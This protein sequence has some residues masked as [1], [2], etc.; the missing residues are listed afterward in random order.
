MDTHW[1]LSRLLS[2]PHRLGFAAAALLLGTS[3]VWWAVVLATRAAGIA[4]P[5]AVPPPAA[6]G[7]VMALGFMPLFITGFLFTAGPRW[8]GLPEVDAASLRM[9]VQTIVAGWALAL[10]GFHAA[11]LLAAI[12]VAAVA[13]GWSALVLRFA[14]LVRISRSP[15]K[16]HAS[17]VAVAGA[18]GAVALWLAAA[19]LA[20]D[21]A[22]GVRAA[23]QLALWGFLAP[24]FAIVSHRM[25]PFFTASALPLH[26]AW[27]P[28]ALLWAMLAALVAELPFAIAELW[29]WPLP[30]AVRWLQVGVELPAAALLLWLALRWGLL[31]GLKIRLLAMLHVG[32]LWLGITFALGAVSHALVA[33]LG[34]AHSFDLAPQHALTMGYLGSTLLAM[35]TRVASGHSGR[36]LVADNIV[37][38]LFWTLQAAVLLRLAAAL[39]P[40]AATPLLLAAVSGWVVAMAGWALRYGRWLGRPRADGRPG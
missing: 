28:D 11:T 22:T 24:V 10:P 3:A 37:W 1:R 34:P 2:A 9:P 12:G 32:F 29:R 35:A 30:P 20:A 13:L 26:D 8:L 6:H 39:W 19:A 17:L 5:W 36:P 14:G 15:D 16:L 27:R 40:V 38:S 33:A 18:V 31:Q 7:L 25:L 21:H 23:T 4:L